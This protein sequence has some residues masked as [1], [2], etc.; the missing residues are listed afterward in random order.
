MSTKITNEHLYRKAIVYVRQ[1]TP[2]QVIGNRE[3]QRLQYALADRA[4]EVGFS[5]VEVIDDDLGRSGAGHTTRP[6]FERLV[7]M[8]C[9]GGTGAVFCIE[10]SRLARNG[11]DWHHLIDFCALVGTVII[12]PDGVYDPR[13]PNDRL[14]LGLKGTMS[15]FELTLFRQRSF[16]AKRAKAQRGELQ[17]HLPI[18]LRWSPNGRIELEPDR[19]AQQAIRAVFKRFELL[20]SIRQVL[21]VMRTEKI[22]LPAIVEG[23]HPRRIEWKLPVY[24]TVHKILTNPLYA[25]AYAYGKTEARTSVIDRR[26]HKTSGHRKSMGAWTALIKDHHPGYISW[27]QFERNQAIVASNAH[28]KQCTVPKAGRGGRALLAGLVRCR[29]C[30]RMLHVVYGGRRQ[31]GARYECRGATVNHGAGARCTTFGALRPDEAVAR[32]LLD[33][34]S[35][36]AIADAIEI[37]DRTANEQSAVQQAALFELEQARYEA[38][39]AG[40]RYESVDPENRLVA[41][42]LESRW[43]AALDHVREAERRLDE[44]AQSRAR[45]VKI[46]RTMLESLADSLP[47]IWNSPCADM[48]TKQRIVRTLVREIVAEIDQ[49]RSEIVLAVHW[50]GGRHTE[51]RVPKKRTGQHDR[52]ASFEAEEVVRRMVGRW[53]DTEIAA[54]LNRL[55]LRT[56]TGLTWNESRVHSLRHRM[57]LK[58]RDPEPGSLGTLT[59]NDA[60][61]RLGVSN[62]VVL[63]LI[64]KGLITAT[65]VIRHAPY[66]IQPE[67]LSSPAVLAAVHRTRERGKPA[68]NW[69]TD[70]RTLTLPGVE[71]DLGKPGRR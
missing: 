32:A 69:A 34:V 62:R 55:G 49:R 36:K 15:E 71:H 40:R 9:G 21:L 3:S 65:Q 28:M 26:A 14:L 38:K 44:I 35:P 8:V 22:R 19:R 24:Q 60:I 25:G 41:G 20:G 61:E 59:L 42:E 46:D 5:D 18:G 48:R 29:R 51:I 13:L 11:R 57:G 37:A 23:E 56:G 64:R 54:T 39:V 31:P 17:F 6:G 12:D 68:R 66:E 58:S 53:P 4:K 10:A 63:G 7:A 33:A 45:S 2:G 67:S 47:T 50:H 1:S 70:R 27:E 30:G 43:N 16:E 52:K